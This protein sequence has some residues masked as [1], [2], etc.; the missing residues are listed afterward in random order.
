MKDSIDNSVLLREIAIVDYVA[1]NQSETARRNFESAMELDASLRAAVIEE[2]RFRANMEEVGFLEPV[3]MSNFDS[4][5]T[6]IDQ[7]EADQ[8]DSSDSSLNSG[9]KD[10]STRQEGSASDVMSDLPEHSNTSESVSSPKP[11][12]NVVKPISPR[13][14][15]R[16]SIAASLAVF[17]MVFGGFYS[18]M[19]APNFDTLSSKPASAEIKFAELSE[20][21]RLAKVVLSDKIA[22]SD[23]SEVLTTY[24]LQTF[25]SGAP[26]KT[27][28]VVASEALS[29][30]DLESM[31]ADFRIQQVDIFTVGSHVQ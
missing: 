25:E 29:K 9:L 8:N 2:Q 7:Y 4:L 15:N 21:G 16:Y 18:N 23:I 5:A 30:K 11:I 3:S 22:Q 17:A 6:R 20:Q 28:Y 13:W 1:D 26:A 10:Q 31:Q 24:N 12:S 19:L 14:T 27:L